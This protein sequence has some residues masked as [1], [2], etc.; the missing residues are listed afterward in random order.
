MDVKLERAALTFCYHRGS[1]KANI[2]RKSESR[3]R[4]EV[5][6]SPMTPQGR[7]VPEL[8]AVTGT[9]LSP[10]SLKSACLINSVTCN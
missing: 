2:Q 1:D 5:E 6:L 4:R 7:T 3:D 9:S 10:D 8:T